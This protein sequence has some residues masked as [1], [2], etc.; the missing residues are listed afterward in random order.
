MFNSTPP[1]SSRPRRTGA[2]GRKQTIIR[3][4]TELPY[5]SPVSNYSYGSKVANLP[6]PPRLSDTKVGL[7][8][9]LTEKTAAVE[10]RL[11]EEEIVREKEREMTARRRGSREADSTHTSI[12]PPSRA[13]SV[14]RDQSVVLEAPLGGLD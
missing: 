6:K 13:H 9:A 4:N 12:P 8:D 3:E 11:Q 14:V 2:G 10:A 5:V 1:T 7:A